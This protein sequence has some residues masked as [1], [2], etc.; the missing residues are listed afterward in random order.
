MRKSN[1]D[2]YI[3]KITKSLVLS[4]LITVVFFIVYALILTYSSLSEETIPT[5]NTVIMIISILVG[6]ISMSMKVNN[7]GWL[8][9]GIV[10]ILYMVIIIIFS[11]FY[12]KTF[13]MDSY[14]LIKSLIGLIVGVISGIIGINL[15]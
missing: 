12:N 8:N 14:I 11:S 6:S 5:I 13:A 15:K 9:G 2:S 10:G 4:F 3:M 7:K 1:S